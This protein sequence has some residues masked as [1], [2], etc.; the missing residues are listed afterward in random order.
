MNIPETLRV[1]LDR[2]A[3]EFNNK[4]LVADAQKISQKYRDNKGA[5]LHL[6]STKKEAVAYSVSR[7]PATFASC[8]FALSHTFE[9]VDTPP[10]SML[11]M[12]SGTGAATWA[13]LELLNLDSIDC[14]EREKSMIEISQKLM[15]N[16]DTPTKIN[17]QAF[18]LRRDSI[19]KKYDMVVAA[20]VLNEF[21]DSERLEIL[22]N[23]WNA[24]DDLLIIIEPGT[25]QSFE[26]MKEMRTILLQNGGHI[27][28]P[29]TH[30]NCCDIKDGD[31][32]HFSCRVTRSK[33][34]KLTKQGEASFED[35]KFTY[36]A[37]S[38]KQNKRATKRILR[39][40]IY[41][42]KIVTLQLC[43][44]NGIKKEVVSKS[45]K[46]YKKARDVVTGD[47]FENSEV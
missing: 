47:S 22:Q 29:C 37:F 32:C 8:H 26:K 40:P 28:A 44:E 4:D 3:L 17:W 33:V 19:D 42:P 24:T 9:F 21:T 25:P 2:L 12:G 34:H 1:E 15:K 36:L 46:L 20:Y 10:K 16:L 43:T 7:M 13:A 41:Q 5:N 35:E 30:E 23:L 6:L 31:W 39:H 11:D 27:I 38:K 14:L 18:D 45:N